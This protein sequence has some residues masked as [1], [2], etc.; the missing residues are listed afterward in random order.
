MTLW[1]DI[2]YGLRQLRKSPGFTI[3]AIA[4]LALGIGANTAIFTVFNQVLLSKLPVHKA[5]ELVLLSEHSKAETGSLTTWGWDE[6]LTFTYPAYQE[7]RDHS[8]EFSGLAA[9]G[10]GS[11]TMV[12]SK[13][14]NT[15]NVGMVTG[16]YFGVLGIHPA[17]GRLLLPSDDIEH[18]GNPVIVLSEDYWRSRFGG[19]P[20]VLNQVVQMNRQS[21]TIVGVAQHRGFMDKHPFEIFVPLAIEQAISTDGEDRL[22]NPL[23]RWLV[24]FGRLAPGVTR[25]SV[26]AELTPI[27]LNWRREVLET[28]THH[29]PIAQRAVWLDSHISLRNGDRGLV[30]LQG[31]IGGLLKVLEAMTLTVLLIA[32]ANIANLLLVKTARRY[33]E[34]AVRG[35]LG[36]SRMRILQQVLTEGLLLGLTGA[37]VG[38]ILGWLGLQWVLKIIPESNPLRAALIGRTDWRILLF[39][40]ALG[41]LISVLFSAGPAFVGTSINLIRA[42]HLQSGSVAGG[43]G[44]RNGLVSC[45]IALSLT[46]LIAASVFGWRLYQLRSIDPGF[47]PTHLWTFY[48]N[49]RTLGKTDAEIRNEYQSITDGIRRVPGVLSVSCSRNGLLGGEHSWGPITVVG[50]VP[51]GNEPGTFQDWVGPGFFSTTQIPLVAGREFTEDDRFGAQEV[52]V[53]DEAFVNHYF[54][55]DVRAAL[56]G[57]FGIAKGE[58]SRS[59]GGGNAG[60]IQIVGVIP[61]VRATKLDSLP[62]RPFFYLP[63][64]QTYTD[65]TKQSSWHQANFYLRVTGDVSSLPNAIRKLVH[66]I[67]PNLP[68]TGLQ[69]MDERV[70]DSIFETRL[71]TALAI[72]ISTLAVLLAAIGLYG[73][74]AFSVAQ[75]TKEIGIRMAL[76]ASREH[77]SGLVIRQ[78]GYLITVGMAGGT[79]LGWLA[80]RVLRSEVSELQRSPFWLFPAAGLALIA[81]MVIAG[82]LPARRAA[83]VEPMQSLRAE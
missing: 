18:A 8:H 17:L 44:L 69:T 35:A 67:D 2:R 70:S 71:M 46:L 30:L 81:S 28:M 47:T 52:A 79:A 77:I 1:N 24:V 6:D 45:E 42:L 48:V 15:V 78:V 82:Y 38:L 16:N 31:W 5:E 72:S 32:C 23:F 74:L 33:G 20:A 25:S 21:L 61:V 12:T 49:A 62:S 59:F 9:V 19:D 41:I 63:Y 26:V 34:L 65:L 66:E 51:A 56:A 13:D 50:Y 37:I 83:S 57:S 64:D 10:F 14:A 22:V 68:V 58:S 75:R 40:S 4:T 27:W 11:A 80:V 7:L 39:G 3:T 54:R 43:H 76:G 29:I 55:G 53:V 36:A 73:V 60:D